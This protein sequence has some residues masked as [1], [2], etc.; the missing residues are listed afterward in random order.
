MSIKV[1]TGRGET[2]VAGEYTCI[3]SRGREAYYHKGKL[4]GVERVP[5]HI[6]SSLSCPI[7]REIQAGSG[8]KVP[9]GGRA[10]SPQEEAKKY[11]C[12]KSK[13]GSVYTEAGRGYVSISDIPGEVRKLITCKAAM[14][15][16]QKP[17]SIGKTR[18]GTA[19]IA[20]KPLPKVNYLC[21]DAKGK[22]KTVYEKNVPAEE[23]KGK[24]CS[25][26]R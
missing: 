25:P 14:Q 15:A 22:K 7:A 12:V 9:K 1:S 4:V 3:Q 24:K 11:S 21:V 8:A 19:L 16:V 5:G 26:I 10:R 2:T 18:A 13:E 23:K 20:G 6:L 17:E